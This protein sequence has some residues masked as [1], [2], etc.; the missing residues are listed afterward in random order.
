MNSLRSR[1]S[2]VV[3]ARKNGR[4]RGRHARGEGALSGVAKTRVRVTPRVRVGVG[5]TG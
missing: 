3:G 4:A 2:E 1:R 5:V